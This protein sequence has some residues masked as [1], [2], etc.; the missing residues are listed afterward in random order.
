MGIFGWTAFGLAIGGYLPVG[1]KRHA[2]RVDTDTRN[3]IPETREAAQ[4]STLGA[5]STESRD[6]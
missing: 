5:P 1:R 6:E 3:R 4:D 2:S